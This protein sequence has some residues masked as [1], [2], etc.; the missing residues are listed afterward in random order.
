LDSEVQQFDWGHH[1]GLVS[2]GCLQKQ[3]S[4]YNLMAQEPVSLAL[5]GLWGKRYSWGVGLVGYMQ[6]QCR[7]FLL[8]AVNC[9]KTLF[10]IDYWH[11]TMALSETGHHRLICYQR[12][13][14]AYS[15]WQCMSEEPLNGIRMTYWDQNTNHV[16]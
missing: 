10:I 14:I 2:M 6:S 1:K 3:V 16:C 13:E 15:V 9:I 7:S 5:L 8:P 11:C 4:S 12:C